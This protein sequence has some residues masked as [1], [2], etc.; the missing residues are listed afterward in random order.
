[1]SS[2]GDIVVNRVL[3]YERR[4]SDGVERF[5][6]LPFYLVTVIGAA[7]GK[8]FEPVDCLKRMDIRNVAC[9]DKNVHQI[10]EFDGNAKI[11]ASENKPDGRECT[12]HSF[13]SWEW[14]VN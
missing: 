4:T 2:Y 1:M 6:F 10:K 8:M 5:R 3:F 14:P 13:R 12:L 9:A 7:S 11:F